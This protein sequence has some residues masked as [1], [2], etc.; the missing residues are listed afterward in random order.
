MEQLLPE[1]SLAA[2]LLLPPH[3]MGPPEAVVGNLESLQGCPRNS[4]AAAESGLVPSPGLPAMGSPGQVAYPCPRRCPPAKGHGE[5][6]SPRGCPHKGERPPGAAAHPSWL[7]PYR[8]LALEGL[9]EDIR[10]IPAPKSRPQLPR[11]GSSVLKPLPLRSSRARESLLAGFLQSSFGQSR[12]ALPPPTLRIGGQTS[13]SREGPPGAVSAYLGPTFSSVES[14]LTLQDRARGAPA[15]WHEASVG[16]SWNRAGLSRSRVVPGGPIPIPS[17]EPSASL[18]LLRNNFRSFLAGRDGGNLGDVCPNSGCSAEVPAG[19]GSNSAGSIFVLAAL[20]GASFLIKED[21]GIGGLLVQVG[22]GVPGLL[23]RGR[24]GASQ[25]Q[26]LM[27]LALVRGQN[28]ARAQ[29]ASKVEV[30]IARR[31]S[32]SSAPPQSGRSGAG[33]QGPNTG[34]LSVANACAEK[35][36]GGF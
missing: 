9:L 6:F 21:K 17:K 19:E 33:C 1:V 36:R 22:G 15:P 35:K 2:L 8:M 23:S 16:A 25:L 24:K 31:S 14:G 10:S 27:G 28:I 18:K 12:R 32:S 29:R 5:I 7:A 30:G 26:N 4:I 13:S 34:R 20:R 11:E 3:T